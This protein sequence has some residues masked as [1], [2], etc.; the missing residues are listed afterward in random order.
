MY[1][2]LQP[3]FTLIEIMIV[4]VIIGILAS[5]A[6]PSYENSMRKSR[7]G[8][9][10]AFMMDVAQREQAFLL[11]SRS[12][13]VGADALT[14]LNMAAPAEVSAFYTISVTDGPS[15]APD[16][17][18]IATPIAGGKQVPDGVLRLGSDGTKTRAGDA[19]KW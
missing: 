11:D 8:T 13:A 18:V 3:G 17:V 7:R 6:F 19:S 15:A 14:T 12:Y 5:I 9:A 10:Q 2:R 1:K 16:F 4:V